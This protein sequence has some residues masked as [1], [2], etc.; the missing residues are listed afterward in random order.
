MLRSF[1]GVLSCTVHIVYSVNTDWKHSHNDAV[2]SVIPEAL[3]TT[4]RFI[5]D[6][7]AGEKSS[8]HL[9][10]VT[11]RILLIYKRTI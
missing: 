11:L 2:A 7:V 8:R 9:D 10:T 4:E 6:I 5:R 3:N 1:D